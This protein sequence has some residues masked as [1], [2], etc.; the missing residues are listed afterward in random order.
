MRTNDMLT[1]PEVSTVPK[2]SFRS[3]KLKNRVNVMLLRTGVRLRPLTKTLTFGPARV[4]I[5]TLAKGSSA[6]SLS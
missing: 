3:S 4:K 2:I 1:L 6:I 5:L